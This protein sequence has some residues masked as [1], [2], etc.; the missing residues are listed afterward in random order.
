M[1]KFYLCE[2]NTWNLLLLS[3]DLDQAILEFDEIVKEWIKYAHKTYEG[4][5]IH[6]T[7]HDDRK[8]EKG[9]HYTKQIRIDIEKPITIAKEHSWKE[10]SKAYDESRE[11][12]RLELSER[13]YS[14]EEV[15]KLDSIAQSRK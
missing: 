5:E 10:F 8:M 3:E 1:K 13:P 12:I 9:L 15:L 11:S 7:S 14:L 6:T 4:A 2:I